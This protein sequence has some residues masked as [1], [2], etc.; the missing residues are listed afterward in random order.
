MPTITTEY[1]GDMLFETKLGNH[2]LTIDVPPVMGG[3]D[4]GPEPPQL[5]IASLGSCV[6]ALVAEYCGHK[7]IDTRDMTVDVSFEKTEHPTRLTNIRVRVNL[8]HA[9]CEEGHRKE[10][11]TRVAQHCPVHETIA[12]VQDIRFDFVGKQQG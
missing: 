8:P 6:G 1:R 12:T 7:G 5:F 2:V 10:V 4:R 11:L 3:K 9:D